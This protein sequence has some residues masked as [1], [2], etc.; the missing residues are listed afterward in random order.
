MFCFNSY[1]LSPEFPYPTPLEDCIKVVKYV[2]DYP[3]RFGIDPFRVAV[4]GDSAGGNMA[5][6]ISIRLHEVIAMQFLI[7][8]CLQFFNFKTTS[9]VEN[10]YYFHDSI[11]NPMSVV[12]ITNYLGLSPMHFQDFLENNHTSRALKQSYFATLVDQRKWLKKEF[13]RNKQLIES[14]NSDL[15]FGN[16]DLSNKI[17]KVITDPFAAPLM[18][19]DSLLSN[20]PE[21]YIVTCGYDFIRDDGIMYAERLK[22]AGT[23]VIHRHYKAGFHHAWFFPHGPLKIKVAEEIVSD[24][25]RALRM[26]L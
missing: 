9:F 14:L 18:G 20:I 25:I 17:E 12:F 23:K 26:R 5:A 2:T 19:N 13:V 16:D 6:S 4:G 8:P 10:T 7:V 22:H 21:A 24:L 15:N 3:E 1:R 11:N